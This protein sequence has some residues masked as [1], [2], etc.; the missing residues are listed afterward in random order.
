MRAHG[1]CPHL[2]VLVFLSIAPCL[3]GVLGPVAAE[4][5][6]AAPGGLGLGE[7]RVP[8]GEAEAIEGLVRVQIE[9]MGLASPDG[10][11]K[12]RGQH[13]KHHGFLVAKFIVQGNLPEEMRAGVFREPRTYTA[14]LRFSNGSTMIDTIPDLHGMA[15][16]LLGVEG[17]TV[18]E[19]ERTQDFVLV[20]TP[21]FFSENAASL[22]EFGKARADL[23]SDP[24]VLKQLAGLSPEE[25]G[26]AMGRLLAERR[27]REAKILAE[28]RARP[29]KPSPLAMEYFSTTPYRLGEVAVKY[30]A[31]PERVPSLETKMEGQNFLREAMVEQLTTRQERVEFGF[32]V[33]RQGD[34][35]SMPIEDPTVEWSSPWEKVATI[36]IEPQ[37]FDFPE[38]V[39]WGNLLSY[40]PWHALE[41]HRPLGG[42]NRARRVVYAASS[43]LRHENLGKPPKEPS[44][45]DIPRR[46]PQAAA[47]P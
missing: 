35:Q 23:A 34:P 42:I 43:A 27:P 38:R 44:E 1:V 4:S 25:R 47:T 12:A 22:L 41:A 33:Q 36:E 17:T 26:K 8:P 29:L 16:K 37:V 7:E 11:P 2:L 31:R 14:I 21:T 39:E 13:P 5:P 18:L 24:E 28:A 40:T 32:Y 9:E 10:K 3:A 19:D 20:D 6:D 45:A 15:I 46:D 30:A